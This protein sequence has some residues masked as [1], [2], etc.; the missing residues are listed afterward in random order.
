M[1]TVAIIQPNYIPWKGYFDIINMVDEFVLFE[2]VQYT[3]RDWRNRNRVKT[4]QGT[5]WLSVPV[6]TRGC[7]HQLISE[8]RI[9]DP[10]WA[11]RHWATIEQSYRKGDGFAEF[12]D[13]LAD[14]YATV[15]SMDRLVD[16][17]RT[18]L[19]RVNECLSIDTPLTTSIDYRASGA[20]TD[21]LLAVCQAAGATTYVSGPNARAYL[22]VDKFTSEG[23]EVVYVDYDGYPE[24]PQLHGA[25]EHAVSIVDLILSV[26][27]DATRYMKTFVPSR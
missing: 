25:F 18:L 10:G 22:E 4:A 3:S 27:R 6:E 2:D 20:R 23:I 12:G 7:S 5:K 26:G 13:R 9:S 24:Y 8:A 15:A 19:E 11:R 1:K 16:V 21:R 14:A 17:N